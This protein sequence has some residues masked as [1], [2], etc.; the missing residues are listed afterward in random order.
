MPLAPVVSI[1]LPG[2]LAVEHFPLPGETVYEHY[3]PVDER[4][5]LYF[6]LM[7]RRCAT[8]E[9][10]RSFRSEVRTRWERVMQDGFNFDDVVAREGLED[11]YTLGNGWLEETLTAQDL[12]IVGWRTLVARYHRGIQRRTVDGGAAALDAKRTPGI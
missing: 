4:T 9:E 11:G 5:H 8:E 7:G 2:M 1:W 6:Q 3:V 12:C 10:E